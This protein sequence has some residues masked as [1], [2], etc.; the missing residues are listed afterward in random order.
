MKHLVLL[1]AIL[2]SG[3]AWLES[4]DIPARQRVA[5]PDAQV[6]RMTQDALALRAK[7]EEVRV[8]QAAEADRRVRMREYRELRNLDNA[9]IPLER[10]LE[11]A[12]HPLPSAVTGPSGT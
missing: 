3:C 10:R 12:G 11:G 2:L 5:L 7:A 6:Q 4:V 1:P 9:R 8:H